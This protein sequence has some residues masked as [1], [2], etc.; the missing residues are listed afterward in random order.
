MNTHVCL[1]YAV[2]YNC[3]SDKYSSHLSTF[4]CLCFPGANAIIVIV[5]AIIAAIY[6]HYDVHELT[7]T[8]DIKAGLPPIQLPN[9][10]LTY[11]SSNQT[12]HHGFGEVLSVSLQYWSRIVRKP[13]FSICENKGAD[14]LQG[15]RA[16]DQRLCFCY[17]DSTF[18]LLPKSK[19]FKPVAI[20][21]GCTARFVSDLV[22][23]P[24]DRFSR[25]RAN[26]RHVMS[27]FQT[28]LDINQAVQPWLEA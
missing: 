5:A 1:T 21:C 28:K 23:N 3:Y 15:N 9:F 11:Q 19:I 8:G 2:I 20:F 4:S 7:I 25:D 27:G 17:I 14:Q 10:S 24:E 16:A 12:V 6:I 18:P 22:G 13:D 26:L